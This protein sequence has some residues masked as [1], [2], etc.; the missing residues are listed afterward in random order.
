MGILVLVFYMCF[1]KGIS[2]LALFNPFIKVLGNTSRKT[3]VYLLSYQ[4]YKRLVGRNNSN[5]SI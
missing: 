2:G 1:A 4:G 3:K 5:I